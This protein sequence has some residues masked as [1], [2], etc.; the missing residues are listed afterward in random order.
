MRN[1]TTKEARAILAALDGFV[2]DTASYEP[3]DPDPMG[4]SPAEVAALDRGYQ[5]IAESIGIPVTVL[6]T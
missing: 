3:T 4:W 6:G 5:K 1:L 2:P